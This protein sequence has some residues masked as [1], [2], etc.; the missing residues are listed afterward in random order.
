MKP[1]FVRAD[2]KRTMLSVYCAVDDILLN[3]FDG[4]TQE[5]IY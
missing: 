4:V 3:F 5:I 2:V 1:F